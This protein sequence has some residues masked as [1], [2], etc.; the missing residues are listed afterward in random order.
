MRCR[1]PGGSDFGRDGSGAQKGISDDLETSGSA[2]EHHGN[3][4]VIS[5][6]MNA[7][8]LYPDRPFGLGTLY[9]YDRNQETGE[10]ERFVISEPA[11]LDQAFVYA[12]ER[13]LIEEIK[14]ELAEGRKVQVFA[15]IHGSGTL[16]GGS[17]TFS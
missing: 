5:T 12:K 2:A 8:L 4:S 9:G 3:A 10:R 17:R 6:A 1:L 15:S 14:S 7:L 11:D 16:R 13:R